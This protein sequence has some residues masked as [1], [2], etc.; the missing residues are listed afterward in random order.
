M[1]GKLRFI[2]LVMLIAAVIFIFCALSC[3]TLGR[4]LYIGDFAFG[5]EQ[6]RFCYKVYAIV[7]AA[8]FTASFFVK[9]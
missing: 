2:S 3:P 6:W 1:K 7:M 5:V 8:L 4:T 9:K